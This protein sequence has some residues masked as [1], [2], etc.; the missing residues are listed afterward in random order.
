MTDLHTG[1]LAC[2]LP[3]LDDQSEDDLLSHFGSPEVTIVLPRNTEKQ[4]D[5][6]PPYLVP[7]VSILSFM[8]EEVPAFADST[9]ELRIIDFGSGQ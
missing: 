3:G 2:T 5:S 4:S 8:M 7:S 9:P 6:L 1:N